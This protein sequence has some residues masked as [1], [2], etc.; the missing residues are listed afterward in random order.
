[1]T[2]TNKS[3]CQVVFKRKQFSWASSWKYNIKETQL[4][5]P[6][7]NSI[8]DKRK[9]KKYNPINATHFHAKNMKRKPK[10]A[11]KMMVVAVIG[12]HVFYK[13]KES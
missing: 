11:R 4:F 12:N 3:A 7:V 1:M 13:Q 8:L 5:I 10:W 2:E 9:S 6:L